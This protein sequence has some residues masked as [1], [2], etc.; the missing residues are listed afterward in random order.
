[1]FPDCAIILSQYEKIVLLPLI[2]KMEIN[3]I[4]S[5]YERKI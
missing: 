2:L 4:R 1:M 3:F 5:D